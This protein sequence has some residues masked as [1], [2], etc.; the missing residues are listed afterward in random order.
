MS[1]ASRLG[2]FLRVRREQLQPDDLGLNV[3][4]RRRVA[5]LRR[6]EVAGL[7]GV[8]V[9]YYTRLE[10]GRSQHPTEPVVAA[11]ARALRLDADTTAH[12]HRLARPGPKV[13]PPGSAEQTP[14]DVRALLVALEPSPAFV[15][16]RV[17][18][19]LASNATARALSPLHHEGENLLR[20]I[21]LDPRA[22]VLHPDRETFGERI[23]ATLRAT[24][25]IGDGDPEVD[26]VV[27]ELL[28]GSDEFRRLWELHSVRRRGYGTKR[29]A[30]PVAGELA[31][32]YR[33]FAVHGAD[34]A[35]QTLVAYHADSAVARDALASLAAAVGA[36]A[37]AG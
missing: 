23:V 6:E 7:A 2:E 30:H 35:G 33:T 11:L 28:D 37:R 22:A 17:L 3:L 12:L 18:D 9:D 16:G 32:G 21:F 34:A 27:E 8:S 31:L 4:G 14:A 1:S 24:A 15:V 20:S 26:V 5:G 29:F 19:V 36:A 25:A 13:S 10:Q